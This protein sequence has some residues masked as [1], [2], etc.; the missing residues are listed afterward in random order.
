[1]TRSHHVPP[2][3]GGTWQQIPAWQVHLGMWIR[4]GGRAGDVQVTHLS[5]DGKKRCIG[6]SWDEN[7]KVIKVRPQAPVLAWLPAGDPLPGDAEDAETEA[8]V[9]RWKPAD[10]A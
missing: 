2:P 6:W 3:S 9:A 7:R 10:A 8:P 5:A 1:M 4:P